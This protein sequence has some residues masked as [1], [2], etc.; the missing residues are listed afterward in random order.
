MLHKKLKGAVIRFL[1]QHDWLAR[2]E[3][4]DRSLPFD[5]EGRHRIGAP[6]AH[7]LFGQQY[8][9]MCG[10]RHRLCGPALMFFDNQGCW[11]EEWYV[12]GD[13]NITADVSDWISDNG[14]NPN[15]RRWSKGTWAHWR[16]RFSPD[17]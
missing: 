17:T 7:G 5:G 9:A 3:W 10:K 8:W 12:V 2:L 4:R 1:R 11:H 15:W 6:A 14:I 13:G 16:L